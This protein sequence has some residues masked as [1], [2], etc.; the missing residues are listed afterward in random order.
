MENKEKA[1]MENISKAL[2][3]MDE[4]EKARVL[5]FSEGVAFMAD[6]AQSATAEEKGA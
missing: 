4:P 2:S 3:H 5:A 6:K 1:I